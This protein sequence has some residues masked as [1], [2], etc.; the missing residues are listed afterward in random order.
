MSAGEL[1]MR[2]SARVS[3]TIC[4]DPLPDRGL[5]LVWTEEKSESVCTAEVGPRAPAASG[6]ARPLISPPACERPSSSQCLDEF[7]SVLQGVS[8]WTSPLVEYLFSAKGEAASLAGAG[9]RRALGWSIV[10]RRRTAARGHSDGLTMRSA[11]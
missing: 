3:M 1:W 9:E 5:H 11:G 6:R 10:G 8:D 7:P 4:R 2:A